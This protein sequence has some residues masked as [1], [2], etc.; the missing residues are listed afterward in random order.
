[1]RPAA[2]LTYHSLDESDSVLSVSPEGFAEQ[3]RIL[4]ETGARVVS[5]EEAARLLAEGDSREPVVALTFDDGFR[6]VYEH[7]FPILQRYGFT[8]TIFI[9]TDYCG[10]DNHWPTQPSGVETLPLMTWDEIQEMHRAGIHFGGHTRTH[11]DLLQISPQEAEEEIAV[12]RQTLEER[13][14]GP[15][16]AFA[17]PYGYYDETVKR[18]TAKHYSLACSARLGF[19]R[20]GSDPFALERLDMYYLRSP[21]MFRSLFTPRV[22]AYIQ[23]RRGLRDLRQRVQN[24][25]AP[26][27]A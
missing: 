17:Y 21:A 26:R 13:L 8:A 5:L 14:G 7:G 15:I 12:S 2:I 27:S 23:F 18:L 20:L 24:R 1:M 3:M 19:A 16:R 25:R 4:S 9:V 6:N 10:K 22:G 11:A